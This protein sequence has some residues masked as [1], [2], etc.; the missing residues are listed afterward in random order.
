MFD[1][2]R[3]VQRSG[4]VGGNDTTVA[5]READPRRVGRYAKAARAMGVYRSEP[6]FSGRHFEK[7]NT[8]DRMGCAEHNIALYQSGAW[9]GRYEDLVEGQD[10]SG[11]DTV[12]FS[13]SSSDE[14]S[15]SIDTEQ[16]RLAELMEH[17]DSFDVDGDLA[18]IYEFGDELGGDPYAGIEELFADTTLVGSNSDEEGS[19]KKQLPT[20]PTSVP[21]TNSYDKGSVGG[22]LAV[23]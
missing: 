19:P 21:T 17:D 3:A 14:D 20:P 2:Y 5:R 6:C 10:Q 11:T 18:E 15:A 22:V 7:T 23:F 13:S 8:T 16:S 12:D 1:A 9:R 4:G